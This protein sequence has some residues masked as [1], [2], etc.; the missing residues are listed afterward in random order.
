MLLGVEPICGHRGLAVDIAA[1]LLDLLGFLFQLL[2]LF[3]LA[4]N[5]S[6]PCLQF[7]Y[8]FALFPHI[9]NFSALSHGADP[10]EFDALLIQEHPSFLSILVFQLCQVLYQCV[11]IEPLHVLILLQ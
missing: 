1:L 2:Y 3:L 6:E 11:D 10:A 8:R 7:E 4:L 9:D 5:L